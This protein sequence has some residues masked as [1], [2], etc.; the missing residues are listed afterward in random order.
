MK[1]LLKR[2]GALT[3]AVMLVLAFS[4]AAMANDPTQGSDGDGNQEG[5]TAVESINI[6][7][8]I[9]RGANLE[10]PA[11]T[12]SFTITPSAGAPADALTWKDADKKTI[13]V[14][15]GSTDT[16]PVELK[17][18]N[19]KFTA[20]GVFTYEV[21]EDRTNAVAGYTYDSATK[22]VHLHVDGNPEYDS[23][24]NTEAD[25][26]IC[27][28]VI[29]TETATETI[30][31]DGEVEGKIGGTGTDAGIPFTNLYTKNTPDDPDDPEGDLYDVIVTKNVT[32]NQGDTTKEFNF[33]V[34]M[35]SIQANRALT[36][37]D[38]SGAVLQ[39]VDV[40]T[41]QE[42]VTLW[43]TVTLKHGES[44]T[45]NGLCKKE[46]FR[47]LESNAEEYT[48][49]IQGSRGG[50]PATM[51]GTSITSSIIDSNPANFSATFINNKE[52]TI[53]TGIF[54]N[55]KPFWIM[56]AAALVLILVF[57]GKRK[58]NSDDLL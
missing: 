42:I 46:G 34:Y 49:S 31:D 25:K 13:A 10:N 1:K 6:E 29:V 45:I 12:F 41:E 38:S 32:G 33:R 36:I 17:I 20:K 18:D 28:A 21:K 37:T 47:I 57:V 35:G 58:R 24:D 7:K 26:Y 2:L 27:Y 14:A 15:K 23:V 19:S 11:A 44:F 55:Y 16:T 22:Y 4:V 3:I 9:T 40:T 30:G 5:I 39:T 43:T 8:T 51:Q 54:T 52:G 53:P 48:V 50:T 56:G